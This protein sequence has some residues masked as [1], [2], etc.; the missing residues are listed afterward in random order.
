MRYC[1][2]HARAKFG[3]SK[4]ISSS[5]IQGEANW[6][7]IIR[8]LIILVCTLG[9]SINSVYYIQIPQV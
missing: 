4:P 6:S 1:Q 7:L 9:I 3:D 2:P 8:S 5:E